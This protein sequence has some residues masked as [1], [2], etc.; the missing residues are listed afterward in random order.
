MGPIRDSWQFLVGTF[1]L[2][3]RGKYKVSI[4]PRFALPVDSPNKLGGSWPPEVRGNIRDRLGQECALLKSFHS[5]FGAASCS[6]AGWLSPLYERVT[7]SPSVPTPC[8]AP[9]LKPRTLSNAAQGR[10]TSP[11]GDLGL[12]WCALHIPL[13][14]LESH[15]SG[16]TQIKFPLYVTWEFLL[17]GWPSCLLFKVDP[18]FLLLVYCWSFSCG[19]GRE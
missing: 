13:C 14:L 10:P 4:Y 6:L 8:P 19:V 9:P 15:R 12:C 7:L 3:W 5:F 1:S 11:P 2:K 17:Y 16:G 18:E